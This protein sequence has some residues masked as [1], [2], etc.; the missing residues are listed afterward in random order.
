MG[1]G[2]VVHLSEE[3]ILITDLDGNRYEIPELSKLTALELKKL[4][5]FI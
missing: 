5:L 3:R 1:G 4:D 2:S